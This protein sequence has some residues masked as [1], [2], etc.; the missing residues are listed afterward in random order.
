[1]TEKPRATGM[2][3]LSFGQRR[4]WFLNR[5]EGRV[6]TYSLP[7]A[8]RL[9]GDLDV[10]ALR[11]AL[12]DLIGRHEILRVVYPELDGLP[13]PRVLEPELACPALPVIAVAEAGLPD[14]LAAGVAWG[15]D[16]RHEPPVRAEL[17]RLAPDTHVLLLVIH[18]IATDEWSNGVLARDLRTAYEARLRGTSPDWPPLTARATP[19]TP[20]GSARW[21]PRRTWRTGVR[22]WPGCR[23]SS[24]CRPTGPAPPSAATAAD[25]CRCAWT[26]ACTR[27]CWSWPVRPGSARSW[28]SRPGSPHC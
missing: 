23:T 8:L 3:A 17:Y 7:Y 9:T 14:R 26:P 27:A 28:C 12:A 6:A 1:M 22:P 18:H 20:Y 4:M 19:T 25:R 24:I 13:A 16:I 10:P 2:D 5:L 21:R 15:F 11:A